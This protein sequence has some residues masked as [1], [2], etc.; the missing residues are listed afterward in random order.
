MI[1]QRLRALRVRTGRTTVFVAA[2]L[3]AVLLLTPRVARADGYSIDAV[4][5]DATISADGSLD[6]LEYR[7]FDF[8]GSYH[9]VYWKIPTDANGSLGIETRITAVGEVI[10]GQFVAFEE[11]YSERD[12]TYQLSDYG[13][14]IKV[15]LYA[16]HAYEEAT[17]VIGYTDTNLAA[18]YDDVSELYWKFVSDGWDVESRNVT[19]TV[20]LPVPEGRTVEPEENVRA[21]GHGP[22]D[23]E[24]AF[25]GND[26]VYRA[27]GVG[28]SEFAEA[29]IVFPEDWLSETT[30]RGGR[31]LQTIL[32]EEQAWADEANARRRNARILSYGSTGLGL[33]GTLIAFLMPLAALIRYRRNM[34]PHFDDK[35]FRDVPTDDHPAVLGALYRGGAPEG[36]DFSASLMRLTDLGAVHLEL[37]TLES[38]GLLGRTKKSKDYRLTL[39]EARV[40]ALRQQGVLDAVDNRTILM[41]FD[42]IE[43]FSHATTFQ[44]QTSNSVM[45]S[46]FE[47]V[48]KSHPNSYADAYEGWQAI[49]TSEVARR[50]F[51]KS[52][53]PTG[54]ALAVGAATLSIVLFAAT[55]FLMAAQVMLW[56]VAA[57]LLVVQVITCTVSILVALKLKPFSDEAIEVR[58][59]LKAL[60]NWLRDFTRLKEAVP[61]DVVLWNRLLVMAVVLG[62]ADEVI[63]QLKTTMPEILSDPAIMP[64]YAWYY[65]GPHGRPYQ[66]INTSV[67]SAHH[68]STAA[69]A[70]SS[71]SSGGGGGGGFSGGGGGGFGGGGGGGAF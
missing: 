46:D 8:D 4:D 61:R 70:S 6:V 16:A 68:V 22:L 45:F 10:G 63:E 42:D 5:I 32:A 35:Y 60:R 53:K 18:R 47:K 54:R 34:R 39:D 30:S 65:A 29:R 51:L 11:D 66:S 33:V 67:A 38:K 20:H 41:V 52:S 64:T 24:V 49:V 17:F 43:R 28:T 2:L 59:K 21:W 69:T 13:S 15:K 55:V 14:Y 48:A 56:Y 31:M 58:A 3:I 19:C 40:E 23:G 12:H 36:E 9:G 50:R 27:P 44:E 71:W 37:V 25:E 26:V 57:V 1:A 62:V 7:T